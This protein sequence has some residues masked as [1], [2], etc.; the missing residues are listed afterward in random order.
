M[1]RGLR[2]GWASPR[3]L[4]QLWQVLLTGGSAR[5]LEP[6]LKLA[7]ILGVGHQQAQLEREHA[8][9]LELRRHVLVDDRL[10]WQARWE[11]GAVGGGCG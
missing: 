5:L 3:P 1:P 11:V 9:A 2:V 6:L 8:F 4:F 7:A 10:I